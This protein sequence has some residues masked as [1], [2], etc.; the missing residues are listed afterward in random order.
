MTFQGRRDCRMAVDRWT[1][2]QRSGK[3][4]EFARAQLAAKE[5]DAR[6]RR[7]AHRRGGITTVY[8]LL[9]SKVER[10]REVFVRS[11]YFVL[12]ESQ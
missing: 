10:E 7:H 8:C 6:Q 11:P 2:G 9:G 4:A 3:R 1:V 12:L 5:D